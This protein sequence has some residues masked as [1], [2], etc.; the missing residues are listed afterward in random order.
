MATGS[1]GR[2]LR[3]GAGMAV[4]QGIAFAALPVL[5]RFS[6]SQAFGY[7]GAFVAATSIVANVACLRFEVALALPKSKAVAADLAVLA[8]ASGVLIAAAAG[9]GVIALAFFG[10][11]LVF[12]EPLLMAVLLPVFVL[13]FAISQVALYLAVRESRHGRAAWAIG[14]RAAA[15]ALAQLVLLLVIGGDHALVL[16]QVVGFALGAVIAVLLVRRVWRRRLYAR[17]T[18]GRLSSTFREFRRFPFV[19][20]PQ[21]LMNSLAQAGPILYL[22]AVF[23]AAQFGFLVLAMRLT[24][25]PVQLLASS[26]SQALLP[27]TARSIQQGRP[28]ARQVLRLLLGMVGIGLLLTLPGVL[29]APWAVEV[30][31]GHAWKAAV[32]YVQWLILLGALEVPAMVASN[33]LVALGQQKRFL[34]LE[35]VF[36]P[37]RFLAVYL[38]SSAGDLP[39]AFVWLLPV[40]VVYLLSVI[41]MAITAAHRHDRQR[42][43]LYGG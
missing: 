39:T 37:L 40:I 26:I 15:V 38:G 19:S 16:G 41:A 2:V 42:A 33:V 12:S 20:A 34:V 9:L 32:P 29:L 30:L 6:D 21:V 35:A 31:F 14:L 23:P 28:L 25:A 3:Y 43:F 7:L 13:A 18:A 11:T 27:D 22:S 24:Q 36:L 10:R 17:V 5:A 8:L 1:V 4:A